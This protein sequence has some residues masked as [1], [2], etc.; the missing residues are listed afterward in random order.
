MAIGPATTWSGW[1]SGR[2][3]ARAGGRERRRSATHELAGRPVAGRR[4]TRWTGGTRWTDAIGRLMALMASAVLDRRAPVARSTTS[5][6]RRR[7]PSRRP[8][9]PARIAPAPRRD[10]RDARA[11]GDRRQRS[12]AKPGDVEVR[13]YCCLG[14]GDAPGAGRRRAEGR[15]RLQRLAPRDPPR[16][17]GYLHAARDA[18]AVQIGSG[19]GP[20]IVGPVGIGGAECVPWPVAGPPAAHR[21]EPLR[22]DPVP[23]VHRRPLQRGGEGQAG[24]PY[25]DL[26]VGALLQGQSLQGGRAG[27]AAT[28]H[29]AARTRCPTAPRCRWDYDTVRKIALLL[30]VDKNGKDATEAGFDPENIV[31]WGFEPQRDDLRQA[32]RV[33]EGAARSPRRTARPSRSPTPGRP[34]GTTSTTASGRTTSR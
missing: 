30:T 7:P 11:D 5:C 25:R 10:R 23:G 20:D 16:F 15:R 29:G 21:Q 17:E 28:R 31:Q 26:P 6:D 4:A 1:W 27:R 14:T 18:L 2:A 24:I 33:L 34:R 8:P 32:R 12:S 13:W 3:G 9:R 22:H 19:S